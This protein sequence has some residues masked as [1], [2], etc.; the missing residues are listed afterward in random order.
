MNNKLAKSFAVAAL[1][2][3][4]TGAQ[5]QGIS[6][7]Q[8]GEMLQD[9]TAKDEK[10]IL[11]PVPIRNAGVKFCTKDKTLMQLPLEVDVSA[12]DLDRLGEGNVRKGI[13]FFAQFVSPPLVIGLNRHFFN[14][15]QKMEDE[16]FSS[17]GQVQRYLDNFTNRFSQQTGVDVRF[18]PAAAPQVQPDSEQCGEE[19][20]NKEEREKMSAYSERPPRSFTTP[21]M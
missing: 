2:L 11:V 4:A 12:Q 14:N 5:A 13:A 8:L 21:E 1:A 16:A 10:E 18:I 15:A 3:G 20:E 6:L 19:A 9:K 17:S 7:D